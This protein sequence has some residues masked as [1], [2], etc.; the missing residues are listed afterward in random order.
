MVGLRSLG[1][2]LLAAFFA[3]VAVVEGA[4]PAITNC[5]QVLSLSPEAANQEHQG[6]IRAVVTCYV[7]SSQLCF[8]QDATAGIYV[9]PSPW[10]KELAPGAVVD[11]EG[12][13]G[14]GRFS[15]IMQRARITP[16]GEKRT[17]Q[18]KPIA[19]EQLKSGRFDCQWVQ[20]EG[21]VQAATIG[22][23]LLTLQ[24][25]SGGSVIS[26]LYFDPDR[27]AT[28]WVDS[29]V[30]LRGVA[31]T[32]Y[33]G[34]QLTGFGLFVPDKSDV[35]MLEMGVDPFTRPLRT[36]AKLAWFSPDGAMDHRVRLRGLVTV[37]W[38]GGPFFLE[39]QSGA[40]QVFTQPSEAEPKPGDLVELS[41]FIRG[42]T[43]SPSLVGA[44]WKKTGSGEHPAPK[45]IGPPELLK[46]PPNGQLV[47]TEGTVLDHRKAGDLSVILLEQ[48]G[49]TVPVFSRAS[50]DDN[51]RGVKLKATGAWGA[52]PAELAAESGPGVWLGSTNDLV[53]LSRPH[54]PLTKAPRT[55]RNILSAAGICMIFGAFLAWRGYSTAR[56]AEIEKQSVSE[57]L[58]NV[59]KQLIQLKES[60][61]RLGRDLHDHIIQS[62]YAM[63]LNIEEC[64]QLLNEPGKAEPRLRTALDEVNGV[65]RELRNV[66]QGLETN[67]IQPAEFRTA[68]K[69]LALMLGGET[70]S[71]VRLDLDQDA[72]DQL[73]PPQATELVHIAREALSN[74]VRH[75]KALTTTFGLHLLGGKIRF[76]IE[77]DGCGFD[78]NNTQVK[79]YGLRNMAKRAE[80]LGAAFE[81]Q[82]Q[83]GIGTRINLDIPKQKQHFSSSESHS[84]I[85]R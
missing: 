31:G 38:P 8:V 39:D 26:V 79:G 63:G 47:S 37:A 30:Q 32:Y 60:R 54:A 75:G 27:S 44:L 15:P 20:I 34:D 71:R 9:S 35:T 18:A 52:C 6:L 70:S 53:V 82:S 5:A 19:I 43:T 13:T 78:T 45:I 81:I 40:I 24:V 66:I 49:R 59:E 14:A 25:V 58:S 10:P 22:N 74:S 42:G 68:L 3:P 55:V 28:N 64:R 1:Q 83:E 4:T 62:I 65:I 48:S 84:R 11:V 56:R 51:L 12:V 16:T 17:I 41:G 73:T 2:L 33:N 76:S 7:P 69:S 85:N 50:I 21:V 77:D 29:R 80:G 23:N 67:A 72:L 36:A 61:E 57:R 46:R